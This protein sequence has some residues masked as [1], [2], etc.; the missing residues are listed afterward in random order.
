MN[1]DINKC[2]FVSA[3]LSI[4][5]IKAVNSLGFHFWNEALNH[6]GDRL[7]G[8]KSTYIK[9]LR[10][11][12][13]AITGN[14]RVGWINRP[15]RKI[16][17]QVYQKVK[18]IKFED[19]LLDV[20]TLLTGND[21]FVDNGSSESEYLDDIEQIY[22]EGKTKVIK[23]NI[24]ERNK[25]VRKVCLDFTSSKYFH[26]GYSDLPSIIDLYVKVSSGT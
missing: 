19:Y 5:D 21:M 24:Y 10:D 20:K 15:T 6:I 8:Y 12:F 26:I 1:E 7:G 22:V 9:N 13:D 25:K 2:L 18:E 3:F 11:E 4:Y 23:I 14:H 17:M 16:I